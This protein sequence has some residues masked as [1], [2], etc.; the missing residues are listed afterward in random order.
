LLRALRVDKLT[1]AA[2]SATL[3]L[4]LIPDKLDQIPLFAM[5]S[6]S[7]ESLRSRADNI[8]ASVRGRDPNVKLWTCECE[9][10]TGGGTLPLARLASAGVAVSVSGMSPDFIAARLR[11][12]EL[13]LV[14]RLEEIAFVIDLRT[15]DPSEDHLV[16]EALG[17]LHSTP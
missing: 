1:L 12:R 8:C 17:S 15:V 2:L 14:G 11:K 3:G 16:V 9:S 5:L 6:V 7:L 10:T 13:P 4:F